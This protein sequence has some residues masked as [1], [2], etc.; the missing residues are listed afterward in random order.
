[1][2]SHLGGKNIHSHFV[3]QMM[4]VC[5]IFLHVYLPTCGLKFMVNVGKSSI[6]GAFG[7]D[8]PF[9]SHPKKVPGNRDSFLLPA[10]PNL[11]AKYPPGKSEGEE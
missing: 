2:C 10:C 5:H 11:R 1:M 9:C 4:R 3:S 8:S 6:H 7:F